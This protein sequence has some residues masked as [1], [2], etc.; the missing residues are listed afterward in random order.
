M[1][2]KLMALFLVVGS[3][4]LGAAMLIGIND[5]PAGLILA[6]VAAASF[7]LA[8]AHSWRKA[9]PFVMLL[10]ASLVGF[11]VAAL[12][13]NLL[14]AVGVAGSGVPGV[15]QVAEALHVAFFLAAIFLCPVGVLVGGVGSVVAKVRRN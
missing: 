5:N 1:S 12:L 13:H 15:P 8:V 4:A 7:V 2:K 3:A 10:V 11:P 9:K 6:Y 14:Y